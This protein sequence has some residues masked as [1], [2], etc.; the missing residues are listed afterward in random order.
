MIKSSNAECLKAAV[1]I[2]GTY[3]GYIFDSRA[4][5]LGCTLLYKLGVDRLGSDRR[6]PD[7][8]IQ[9]ADGY[10]SRVGVFGLPGIPPVEE[11]HV[12]APFG[13]VVGD[14]NAALV[15]ADD[16]EVVAVQLGVARDRG[17]VP[18][19]GAA[20]KPVQSWVL[21]VACCPD[22]VA[23]PHGPIRRFDRELVTLSGDARHVGVFLDRQ[24]KVRRR[25][26]QEGRVLPSRRMLNLHR[27]CDRGTDGDGVQVEHAD[28]VRRKRG[29]DEARL[30]RPRGKGRAD[31][32]T[33]EHEEVLDARIAQSDRDAYTG[34][35]R[36]R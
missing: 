2:D 34:P 8:H 31:R 3:A 29:R 33:L 26:L 27:V 35:R 1:A 13:E 11:P 32:T 7:R 19:Q 23:G 22:D 12:L 16:D 36:H 17:G 4:D 24:F 30:G 14:V 15:A 21:E 6:F 20:C 18:A 10:N 28:G 5:I 9:F 25:R